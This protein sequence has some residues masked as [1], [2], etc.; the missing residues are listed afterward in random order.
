MSI[1]SEVQESLLNDYDS[2]VH[3]LA[4][5]DI[6]ENQGSQIPS[7]RDVDSQLGNKTMTFLMDRH[8][9]GIRDRLIIAP[10]LGDLSLQGLCQVS[11]F[12]IDKL[13]HGDRI[14]TDADTHN[15]GRD[16]AGWRVGIALRDITDEHGKLNPARGL[17]FA[18]RSVYRQTRL[19]KAEAKRMQKEDL[20][21]KPVMVQEQII[22]ELTNPEEVRGTTR[23]IHLPTPN[24]GIAGFAPDTRPG[25]LGYLVSFGGHP[26]AP[27]LTEGRLQAHASAFNKTNYAAGVRRV[28]QLDASK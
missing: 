11:N 2:V 21:L 17:M 14:T 22:D 27:E 23:L 18:E 24:I 28:L 3:T 26:G 13:R 20:V 8:Y 7:W 25:P 16:K 4:G 1:R 10:Y 19:Q 12:Q 15:Q 5:L 6:K 9:N